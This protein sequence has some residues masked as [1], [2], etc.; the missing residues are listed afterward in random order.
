MKRLLFL[1]A[2]AALAVTPLASGFGDAK[3]PACS[4]VISGG[5]RK[6]DGYAGTLGGTATFDFSMTLAAPACAKVTYTFYVSVGGAPFTAVAGVT[7]GTATVVMPQ[8]TYASAQQ[9]VCV[10]ATS[11]KSRDLDV[12]DRAPDG[13]CLSYVLNESPGNS[14]FG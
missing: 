9:S 6:T 2:V 1:A 14:S 3:G 8:Q 10:Y 13:G 11:A 12:A 4:D 7:D 5:D